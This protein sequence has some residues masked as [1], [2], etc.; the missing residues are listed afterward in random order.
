MKTL[1]KIALT[2][3]IALSLP[4]GRAGV[5]FAQI[6]NQPGA[7]NCLSYNGTSNYV[8][9]GQV[10][11]VA[12]N[13]T[14]QFTVEEWVMFNN[15]NA[16]Q[17]VVARYQGSPPS[18]VF[19]WYI[20]MLTPGQLELHF[21]NSQITNTSTTYTG[22]VAN[23]W[24]HIAST[25]DGTTGSFYIDGILVGTCGNPGGGTNPR[26]IEIGGDNRGFA[27]LNGQIDEVRLWNRAIT[28]TEIRDNMCKKVIGNETNLVGYWPFDETAGT[29]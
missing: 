12:N 20:D 24:F 25:F 27:F 17:F 22:I 5:S 15:L 6:P 9:F 1:K 14:S 16:G 28:K 29:G 8:D 13:S 11:N 18:G 2:L 3:I 19:G 23:R 21:N 26:P 7:G 4:F 10:N